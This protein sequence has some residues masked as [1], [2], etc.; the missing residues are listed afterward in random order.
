[1]SVDVTVLKGVPDEAETVDVDVNFAAV[2]ATVVGSEVV[3]V[4]AFIVV[5]VR[6]V[7]VYMVVLVGVVVVATIHPVPLPYGDAYPELQV[8][9]DKPG[10]RK[11]QAE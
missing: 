10:P 8:Q 7:P 2:G 5:D 3:V 11:A 6:V 9:T 1:M 4:V